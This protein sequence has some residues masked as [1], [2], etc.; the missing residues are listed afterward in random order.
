VQPFRIMFLISCL[1]IGG[2]EKQL[3]YLAS[4]LKMRGWD[5]Q[6]VIAWNSDLSAEYAGTLQNAGVPLVCLNIRERTLDF[7]VIPRLVK[8][9]STSRPH[10]LHSFLFQANMLARISR[11]LVPVPV[12]ISSVRNIFEGKRVRELA[13][14]LTDSLADI[15]TQNSEAGA[16]RY[17]QIKAVSQQKMAVVLNGIDTDA[18]RPDATARNQLRSLL[19]LEG[20]FVWIT[21]GRLEKAKNHTLLLRSFTTVLQN[22]SNSLLLIV[23]D[24]SARAQIEATVLANHLESHVTLLGARRDVAQLLNAADAFV[25]ASSW[26]GT[27]NVLLEAASVQ[28]VCVATDVGGC[29]GI[30]VD[31]ESGFLVPSNDETALARKMC[32]VMALKATRRVQIGE[33]ARAHVEAH[34]GLTRSIDEWETLYR[35]ILA[36][37]GM[38]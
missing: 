4:T 9:L 23:G 21:V 28:L 35:R 30:I 20:K 29:D 26:E 15:T 33:R 37:K 11:L 10:I 3:V 34:F 8:V 25:L 18:Y 2:A 13:Y 31:N 19:D 36:S 12:Q 17:I 1:G 6:I 24:G 32:H 16:E 22:F 38:L 14:R 5:P 7:R 27:P